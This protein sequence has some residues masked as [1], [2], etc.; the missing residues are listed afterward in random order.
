M[1]TISYKG[2]SWP[3]HPF[4]CQLEASK[5]HVLDVDVSLRRGRRLLEGLL[6]PQKQ[7]K[8]GT[9]YNKSFKATQ[10]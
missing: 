4:T 5:Q 1:V 6:E 3:H 7:K 10:R 9:S 2:S 8:H